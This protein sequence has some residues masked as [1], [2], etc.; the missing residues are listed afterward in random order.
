MKIK[1]TKWIAVCMVAMMGLFIIGCDSG[2]NESGGADLLP[3]MQIRSRS[4]KRP[5][6]SRSMGRRS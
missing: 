2:S 1:T 6:L 3:T 5:L 4:V